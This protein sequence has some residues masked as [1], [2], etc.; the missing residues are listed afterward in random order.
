[1]PPSARKTRQVLFDAVSKIGII[2]SVRWVWAISFDD[3][4]DVYRRSNG[5]MK[6]TVDL[7]KHPLS[8]I[9]GYSVSHLL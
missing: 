8:S 7:P 6:I 2:S 4:H 9:S 5:P 3:C 1:M